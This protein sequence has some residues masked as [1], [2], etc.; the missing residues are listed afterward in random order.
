M[1]PLP[2]S[3]KF[4]GKFI[5]EVFVL[6][7]FVLFGHA[8]QHSGISV[9]RPGMETAPPALEPLTAREVPKGGVHFNMAVELRSLFCFVLFFNLFTYLFLAVLIGSSLLHA[10]FL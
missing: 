10:G 2:S 7:C 5:S 6:F 9:P 3:F 8:T 4:W 1:D